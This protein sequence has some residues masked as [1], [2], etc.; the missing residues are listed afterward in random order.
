MVA[1]VSAPE[2]GRVGVWSLGVVYEPWPAVSEA[3]ARVEELGYGAL[4]YPETADSRESMSAGALL[5]AATARIAVCSGIASIWARDG[6]AAAHGARALDEASGG[7][8]LLGLGVSHAPAVALRGARYERPVAAMRAYL[9][10]MDAAAEA[11][12]VLGALAPRML[13]LAAARSAGAL[14]YFVPPEHTVAARAALGG[15][16]L[17]VELPVV[18]E[19][20]PARARETARRHARRYLA[21]ENY[22]ANLVRLGYGEGDLAA[23]G[24]DALVDRIVA[25][26]DADAIARRVADHHDAGAD[27]VAVQPLTGTLSEAVAALEELAG[28]LGV[29]S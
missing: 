27:H 28:S 3:A 15:A 17:A 16:L 24:S 13:E 5:L 4:W 1:G 22:R 11:P 18:L 26:G 6:R 25:W 8:F 20:D 2:L 10:D 19:T 14:T 23:G 21:L 7:R 29:R 9:D 12:R